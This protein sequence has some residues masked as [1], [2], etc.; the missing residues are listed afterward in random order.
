[1]NSFMWFLAG[2]GGFL[3]LVGMVTFGWS[4]A[5]LR[6]I[7]FGKPNHTDSPNIIA[8]RNIEEIKSTVAKIEG[9]LNKI[10]KEVKRDRA[11]DETSP[12]S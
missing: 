11:R 1:M 10:E 4:I 7:L 12:K 3:I 2:L 5:M 9:R 8:F 6:D